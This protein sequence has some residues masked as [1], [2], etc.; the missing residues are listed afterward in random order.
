M[1]ESGATTRNFSQQFQNFTYKP[2]FGWAEHMEIDPV[3]GVSAKHYG[4][5][6][7]V[8]SESSDAL[9]AMTSCEEYAIVAYWG[10]NPD[11]NC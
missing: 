10:L 8:D 9:D 11:T 3:T 1:T 2:M 5:V 7:A 4:K 6:V